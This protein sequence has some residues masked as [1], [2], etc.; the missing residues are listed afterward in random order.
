MLVSHQADPLTFYNKIAFMCFTFVGTCSKRHSCSSWKKNKVRQ[1]F[2]RKFY[3][4]MRILT[5]IS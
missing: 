3:S 1:F 2:F 4:T 5:M